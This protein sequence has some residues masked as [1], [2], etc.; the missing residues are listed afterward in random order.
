MGIKRT[1]LI[2]LN[3]INQA[4]LILIQF[5][6]KKLK[7]KKKSKYFPL[8]FWGNCLLNEKNTVATFYKLNFFPFCI[9]F[10][11]FIKNLHDTDWSETILVFNLPYLAC[12]P[13]QT[14]LEGVIF[15]PTWTKHCIPWNVGSYWVLKFFGCYPKIKS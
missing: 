3:D 5:Y 4:W 14:I 11:V 10:F 12:P 15:N 8:Y 9:F 2:K 13:S 1:V 7:K 6:R